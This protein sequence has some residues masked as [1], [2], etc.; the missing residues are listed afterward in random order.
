MRRENNCCFPPGAESL[1]SDRGAALIISLSA[2]MVLFLLGLAFLTISKTESD[3]SLNQ[4]DAGRALYIAD[5]GLERFK[6][7]LR[8]DYT[9]PGSDPSDRYLASPALAAEGTLEDTTGTYVGAAAPVKRYYD[10]GSPLSTT[11]T[12]LTAYQ[13]VSMNGG[14][15]AL[16]IK[17]D[18]DGGFIVESTGTIGNRVA[19]TLEA[20]LEPKSLSV[21]DNAIFGGTGA[22]GGLINGMSPLPDRFMSWELA[23]AAAI[24]RSH[25][26]G[27]R[28]S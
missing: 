20:K 18:V 22:S 19:R 26:A 25:S 16:R 5:A 6:R 14:S 28:M 2:L 17:K 12:N 13:Q 1:T 23:W 15:Y 9:Y 11:F 3:I 27:E 10:L 7:D 8:Y 4:R 24:Q 21:W